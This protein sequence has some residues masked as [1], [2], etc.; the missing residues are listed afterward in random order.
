M[1]AKILNWPGLGRLRNLPLNPPVDR[2]EREHLG[3]LIDFFVKYL[4][5]FQHVGHYLTGPHQYRRSC[6]LD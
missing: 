6:G 3:A 5:C 1:F 4:A 2:Y